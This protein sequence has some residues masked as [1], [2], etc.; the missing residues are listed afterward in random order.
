MQK[1]YEKKG[2]F[3]LKNVLNG[4]EVNALIKTLSIFETQINQY[5]IRDLLN[6]VP[7]IRELACSDCLLSIA[8]KILGDKAKPIR[9]VFF[10][11][12][13]DANW[14]VAWHQDTS[15]LVKTKVNM[16]GFNSWREKQGI[17]HVEPPWNT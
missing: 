13:P 11:K 9:A 2:Y 10:D 5:G 1:E 6:K 14:N 12:L 16:P 7:E 15:I 4:N 3:M 8:Q 17:M